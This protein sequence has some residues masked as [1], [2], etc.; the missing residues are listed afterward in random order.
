MEYPEH[1]KLAK[2]KDESQIIGQ[3]LDTGLD[4]MV[5]ARWDD[6]YEE[7]NPVHE[8]INTILDRYFGIDQDKLE[9]EKRQ[10][11]EQL[12]KA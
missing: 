2:V 12:R 11:L 4:G 8:P 10:M 9:A 3:F 5:L 1:E 7:Y 6:D